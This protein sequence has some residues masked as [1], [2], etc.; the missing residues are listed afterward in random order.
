MFQ[1][2]YRRLSLQS[3]EYESG[4]GSRKALVVKMLIHWQC[5]ILTYKGPLGN[6]GFNRKTT[7]FRKFQLLKSKLWFATEG[8]R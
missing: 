1:D 2:I 6:R 4:G 5:C 3:A 7:I 8:E